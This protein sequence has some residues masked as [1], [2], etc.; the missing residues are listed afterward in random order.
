MITPQE[1]TILVDVLNR[2]PKSLA[3]I[4]S[5]NQI[6]P[7]LEQFVEVPKQEEPKP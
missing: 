5:L 4:Y 3:D 1:L 6:V 7:K 2:A